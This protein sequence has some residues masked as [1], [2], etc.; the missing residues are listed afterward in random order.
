MRDADN[1]SF[2]VMLWS[3]YVIDLFVPV[4]DFLTINTMFNSFLHKQRILCFS[5]MKCVTF[6]FQFFVAIVGCK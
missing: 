4:F 2:G 6:Y 5:P 3:V 1:G